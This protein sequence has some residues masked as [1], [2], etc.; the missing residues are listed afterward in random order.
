MVGAASAYLGL[1]DACWADAMKELLPE[2]ALEINTRAF[3]RGREL[4]GA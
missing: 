1:P 4:A 2:K 3:R